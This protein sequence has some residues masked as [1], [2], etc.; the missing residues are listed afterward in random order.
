MKIC[1]TFHN[2]I[3]SKSSIF[4]KYFSSFL[5]CF[6]Q[7]LSSLAPKAFWISFLSALFSAISNQISKTIICLEYYLIASNYVWDYVLFLYICCIWFRLIS[8]SGFDFFFFLFMVQL[9]FVLYC[10]IEMRMLVWTKL[11]LL[12]F[13]DFTT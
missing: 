13:Q 2:D 1:K 11:Q 5:F 10:Y 4:N 8:S 12:L 9:L 6:Y 3:I 7:I